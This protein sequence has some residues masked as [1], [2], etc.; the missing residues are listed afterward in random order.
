MALPSLSSPFRL[1]DPGM[2]GAGWGRLPCCS[3]FRN[4][5]SSRFLL[6][7]LLTAMVVT[8]ASG[9]AIGAG[10]AGGGMTLVIALAFG[11]ARGLVAVT[12]CSD[13]GVGVALGWA[14]AA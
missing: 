2:T 4:W 8:G 14:G 7:P 12:S 3:S 9:M 1:R 5:T 13:G 6:A 11:R 10:G